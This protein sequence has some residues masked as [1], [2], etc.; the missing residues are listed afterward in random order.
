MSVRVAQFNSFF[1]VKKSFLFKENCSYC[2]AL[3]IKWSVGN[4]MHECIVKHVRFCDRAG[5]PRKHQH[6]HSRAARI[7]TTNNSSVDSIRSL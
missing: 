4:Q 1:Y 3:V 2:A 5:A 6:V 7:E